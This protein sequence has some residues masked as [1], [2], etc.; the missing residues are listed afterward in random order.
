MVTA[1]SMLQQTEMSGCK[2]GG[3]ELPC[4]TTKKAKQQITKATFEKWQRENKVEHQS[5]H[6]YDVSLM[7]QESTWF[8]SIV[9]Y[10]GQ[11]TGVITEKNTGSPVQQIREQAT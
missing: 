6:G 1:Q 2:H 11:S 3:G 8:V 5:Y 9:Q 7:L 4:G 10:A